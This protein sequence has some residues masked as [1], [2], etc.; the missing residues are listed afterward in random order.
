MSR[1]PTREFIFLNIIGALV[2]AVIV[3]TG[4]YLF[5][6]ALE[7]MLGNIKHYEREVLGAIAAAGA[8]VWI[9]YFYRRKMRRHGSV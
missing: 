6:H 9:I 1:V 8:L 7:A 2:W 5:G 3:G 4:G